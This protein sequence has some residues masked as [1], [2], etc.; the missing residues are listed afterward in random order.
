MNM[1]YPRLLIKNGIG[2]YISGVSGPCGSV[3]Y[4]FNFCPTLLIEVND[5]PQPT[6]FSSGEI[7]KTGLIR[8]E[9]SFPRRIKQNGNTFTWVVS[10]SFQ[11]RVEVI[12]LPF[13]S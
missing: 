4:R 1:P 3:T 7:E 12:N 9:L 10:L 8:R 5:S 11:H 13:L 2:L 6:I